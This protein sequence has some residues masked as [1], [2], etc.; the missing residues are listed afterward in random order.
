MRLCRLPE[1]TE[2]V[3]L[4]HDTIEREIAAGRFPAPYYPTKAVRVWR[5]DEIDAWIEALP[6][7]PRTGQAA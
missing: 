6:R 2:R 4:S 5:S 7:E 3:A 1:V